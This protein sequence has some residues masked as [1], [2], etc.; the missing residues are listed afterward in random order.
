MGIVQI[1]ENLRRNKRTT[2][3]KKLDG[4]Y[5]VQFLSSRLFERKHFTA[6]AASQCLPCIL[7]NIIAKEAD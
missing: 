1:V 3:E 2:N 4:T 7:I 6:V 5:S